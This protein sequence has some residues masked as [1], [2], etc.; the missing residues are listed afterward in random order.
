[1]TYCM[2]KGFFS[3]AFCLAKEHFWQGRIGVPKSD[4]VLRSRGPGPGPQGPRAPGPQPRPPARERREKRDERNREK[5]REE[6][7]GSGF[8][9]R[10]PGLEVRGS[11]FESNLKPKTGLPMVNGFSS[12]AWKLQVA[13]KS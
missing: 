13:S 4:F 1:M 9:V 12:T 11:R 6:V 8:E 5:Q 10:G 3:L 2:S 7:P